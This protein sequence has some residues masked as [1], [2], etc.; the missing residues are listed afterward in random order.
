MQGLR[1]AARFGSL[2]LLSIAMLAGFGIAGLRHAHPGRRW[3]LPAAVAAVLLVNVEALRAP[4]AYRRFEGIPRIYRLLAME[5]RPVVL[6]E[7]PFYPAHAAFQNADYML[8]STAHW[9][10]LMNGYSG[11]TPSSYRR[12]AWTFWNFPREDAID[13]MRQAGVTHFTVHVNRF[14]SRAAETIDLLS[15]RSD[16]ELLAIS[17]GTGPRLY[18]FR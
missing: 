17:G 8:N 9:R 1:A 7:T 3:I 18:R 14:G 4:F 15:R 12:V 10:P 6:A 16:V 11:Y 2:F 13:A 5:Q